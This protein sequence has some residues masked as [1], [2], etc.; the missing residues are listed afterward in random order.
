MQD[1]DRLLAQLEQLDGAAEAEVAR[2][3]L[4]GGVPLVVVQEELERE[5]ERRLARSRA[6][7]DEHEW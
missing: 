5:V 2:S 6:F 1:V 3:A 4:A 7:Y